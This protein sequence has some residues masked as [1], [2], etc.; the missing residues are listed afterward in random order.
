MLSN[1]GA[2]NLLLLTLQY[3]IH[4]TVLARLVLRH[5][6]VNE[7]IAKLVLGPIVFEEGAFLAAAL[8]RRLLQRR[9]LLG[10]AY[11]H[12]VHSGINA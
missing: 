6:A 12:L 1:L 8:R 2:R 5:I 10:R 3:G 9:W 7:R 4:A 11:G